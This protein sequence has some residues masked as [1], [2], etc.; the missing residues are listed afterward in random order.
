MAR[1]IAESRLSR[2]IKNLTRPKLLIIDEV[3]YLALEQAHASLLF[4][5]ICE[6]YEKRQ[7]G[8]LTSNKAFAD[9]VQ[10]FAGDTIMA[11][12]ALDRLLIA[13]PSSTSGETA[14]GSKRSGRPNLQT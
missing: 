5:A 6:R 7:A 12:A 13:P 8:I 11:S 9:W 1:A 4:Q 14:T 10:V 3:G 2:E